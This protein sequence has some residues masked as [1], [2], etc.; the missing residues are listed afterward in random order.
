MNAQ[1]VLS[2]DE[3]MKSGAVFSHDA[4]YR[5][6][7]WRIWN[8]KKPKCSFIMLNPSKADAFTLDPTVRRCV[9]Y[10]KQWGYGSLTVGN[11]FALKSTDPKELYRSDDPVGAGNDQALLEIVKDSDIAIT[12]WGNHGTYLGRGNAVLNA[13]L[14]L[15]SEKM[16]YLGLSEKGEPLHPLYL[17][18]GAVP[19]KYQVRRTG[20]GG[21]KW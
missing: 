8:T 5:Y 11:I 1:S 16:A 6:K 13:L 7:L 20:E 21:F 15:F 17:L 2:I 10:A 12:A 14:P 3:P 9:D 18:K 19:I 4:K